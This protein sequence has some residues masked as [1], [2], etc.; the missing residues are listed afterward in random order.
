MAMM[1][2][3]GDLR[4]RSSTRTRRLLA[5]TKSKTGALRSISTA[6]NTT[7]IVTG[8]KLLNSLGMM[9]HVVCLGT[10]LPIHVV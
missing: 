3:K 7:K 8:E 6:V 5:G 10:G 9:H 4:R 1:E 2:K